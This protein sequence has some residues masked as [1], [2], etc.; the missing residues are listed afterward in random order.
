MVFKVVTGELSPH[1]GRHPRGH[2]RLRQCRLPSQLQSPTRHRRRRLT[3]LLLSRA[4]P[5]CGHTLPGAT[6][7]PIPLEPSSGSSLKIEHG[8]WPSTGKGQ[9]N[10]IQMI[11]AFKVWQIRR[12][13]GEDGPL[14]FQV[15]FLLLM[16]RSGRL[17]PRRWGVS[18]DAQRDNLAPRPRYD[19]CHHAI[20]FGGGAA[21]IS[22]NGS[23]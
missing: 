11:V 9:V 23:C 18:T 3:G 4:F 14:S 8:C 21:D 1:P 20:A 17:L 22:K 5:Y 16:L 7:E 15:L 6:Q 10:H 19:Q 12:D 2:L 13:C